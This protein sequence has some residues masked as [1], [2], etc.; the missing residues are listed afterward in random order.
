MTA[1]IFSGALS[2]ASL[3]NVNQDIEQVEYLSE[4]T[5]TQDIKEDICSDRM[6]ATL[7]PEKYNEICQYV[8][9]ANSSINLEVE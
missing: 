3:I 6:M 4:S 7:D 1:V 8:L 5:T 9:D 2:G